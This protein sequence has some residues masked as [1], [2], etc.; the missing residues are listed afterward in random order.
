[1]KKVITTPEVDL[2]LRTLW[3]EESRQVHAWLD[4]LAD[5]DNDP[6]LRQM[7]HALP[8]EAGVYVL[9]THSDIRIFFNIAGDT[10]TV[11]DVAKKEAIMTTTASPREKR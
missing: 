1:M 8:G 7:A 10:I 5:W 3:P 6:S 2:A 4:H 11:L 9:P